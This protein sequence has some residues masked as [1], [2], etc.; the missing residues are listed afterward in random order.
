MQTT[1]TIIV[2]AAA[3]LYAARRIYTLF[4][5]TDKPTCHGCKGCKE[6]RQC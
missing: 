5:H 3:A 1:I 6:T 4:R 2:I